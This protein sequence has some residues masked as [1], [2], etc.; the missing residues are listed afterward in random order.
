MSRRSGAIRLDRGRARS[1]VGQDDLRLSVPDAPHDPSARRVANLPVR[2]PVEPAPLRR[3]TRGHPSDPGHFVHR[4]APKAAVPIGRSDGLICL[5]HLVMV[6]GRTAIRL[7][8][9]RARKRV[10]RLLR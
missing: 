10:M 6:A 8:E 9:S 2:A 7:S 4:E 5:P 1:T 3:R